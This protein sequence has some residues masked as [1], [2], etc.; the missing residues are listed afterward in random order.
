MK[1]I[2][3]HLT[4]STGLLT[5][6]FNVSSLTTHGSSKGSARE[7]VVTEFLIA[8]LPSNLEFTTGQI[9]DSKDNI[10][11]Q[12]DIIIYSK[13]SLKLNFGKDQ[14]M[15]PVDSALALIEC[16]S[17]LST[18]SMIDGSSNLKTTLDACV[19][20]KSLIRINPVGIDDGYL[21]QR[22]IP[23]HVGSMA[24]QITGMC[25]TMKKTPF[26]IFAFRGPEEKTLRDS[27]YQYM[28]GNNVDLDDMPDIIT[29][30]D[31]GYYLVKNNGFFIRKVHGNVHYSTGNSESGALMGFYICL[32]KIAESQKLSGNFFPLEQYLK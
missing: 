1:L 7:I 2:Q 29:V 17:S 12:A 27:L 24:E 9:F 14:N 26:I 31:R 5:S 20:S 30:L 8:N 28:T 13:H 15:I 22:N 18:G 3:Q 6:K 23:A 32:V 10:S 11:N 25:A 21:M 4:N 16:K 19:K